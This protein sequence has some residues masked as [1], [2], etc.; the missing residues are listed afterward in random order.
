MFS[1]EGDRVEAEGMG[2]GVG[3][4][5]GGRERLRLLLPQDVVGDR[6]RVMV[7]RGRRQASSVPWY[8]VCASACSR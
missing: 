4:R 5:E 6:F 8:L 7:G 3:G 1:V 2:W